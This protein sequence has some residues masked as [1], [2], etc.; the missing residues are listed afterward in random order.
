MQLSDFHN[1]HKGQT[2]LMVGN[3]MNLH[4]TPPEWFPYPSFGLNTIFKYG[5]VWK[6]TY[7]VAVDAAM[8]R[9]YGADVSARYPDV[10]KFIPKDTT[11]TGDNYIYFTPYRRGICVPGVPIT[12][13]DAPQRGIG[14]TNSM[15]C[16]MQIAVYM[17]FTTLLMIGVEQKAGD[18]VT[19]FWGPDPQMPK[20]QTDEHW[21]IGYMDVQRSNP[22]LKVLNLSVDTY[23]PEDVLPRDDW[24]KWTDKCQ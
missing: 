19:H 8:E 9:Q 1:R 23:V 24:R 11:W 12:N 13:R 22:K 20:A 7:Y 4:K 17:G 21:N 5:G 18:L 6:P 10:P 14:F 3:G 15:T 2:A 16:A